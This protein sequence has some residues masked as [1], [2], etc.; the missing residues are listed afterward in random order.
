MA[1]LYDRYWDLWQFWSFALHKLMLH[2]ARHWGPTYFTVSLCDFLTAKQPRC[3][4]PSKKARRCLLLSVRLALWHS[5][6]LLTSC[7]WAAGASVQTGV[8]LSAQVP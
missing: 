7:A 6:W 5:V 3:P 1:A 2:T 4:S 8:L